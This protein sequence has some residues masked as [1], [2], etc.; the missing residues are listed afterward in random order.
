MNNGRGFSPYGNYA[1]SLNNNQ[2]YFNG[3]GP[4]YEADVGAVPGNRGI[5]RVIV[6]E[7]YKKLGVLVHP[8][9]LGN[10][11]YKAL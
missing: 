11:F 2:R 10:G 5:F 9:G 7:K 1:S 6:N 4:W 3:K 8:P